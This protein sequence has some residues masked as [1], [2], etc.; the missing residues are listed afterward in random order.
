V[1]AN[2]TFKM[3]FQVDR[4]IGNITQPPASRGNF[5]YNGQY[6]DVVNTNRGY[7]GIADML[8]TPITATVPNG[9]N[10]VGGLSSFSGSNYAATDDR[11][12]YWGAYFQDDWKITPD[13]TLNLGLR[14]D[15]FTPYAEVNGRQA[16]F[17]GDNGG[18]GPGGTY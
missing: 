5:T 15:Y 1:H 3:G 17:V 9:V 16:H 2:H 6:S 12:Y 7:N 13:L 18:N 10:N 4:L 8:L 14:W 11:R